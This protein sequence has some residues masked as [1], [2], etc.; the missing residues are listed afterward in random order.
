MLNVVYLNTIVKYFLQ[1]M[2]CY[3]ILKKQPNINKSAIINQYFE[4][5]SL[6]YS[7][8]TGVDLKRRLL[9]MNTVIEY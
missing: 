2:S 3:F 8:Y 6:L 5:S 4:H 7:N 1:I 9:K